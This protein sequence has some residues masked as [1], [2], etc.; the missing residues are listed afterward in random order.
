MSGYLCT[1]KI[2]DR[3]FTPAT[4]TVKR[5]DAEKD[6]ARHALEELGALSGVTATE[7]IPKQTTCTTLTPV[8]AATSKQMSSMVKPQQ[9]EG[10]LFWKAEFL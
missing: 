10:K 8:V 3:E 6:A 1:V 7:P 2:N 9:N 5:V 4:P